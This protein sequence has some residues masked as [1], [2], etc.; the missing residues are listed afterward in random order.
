VIDASHGNSRKDHR[1]QTLVADDI[2]MRLAL[3]ERGIVGLMLESF[4]VADRQE[5]GSPDAA[6]PLVYGQSVTD[7]CIGW[8]ATALVLEQLTDAI[9]RRRGLADTLA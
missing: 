6:R 5:L 1:L 3:G 2:A 7:A 8:D 9:G 4:L